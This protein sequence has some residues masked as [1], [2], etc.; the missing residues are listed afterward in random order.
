MK[1][2]RS[3]RYAVL[4]AGVFLG[5]SPA[6]AEEPVE[7]KISSLEKQ[8]AELKELIKNRTATSAN[9]S[10]KNLTP[11]TA[12][13]E[14]PQP[15]SSITGACQNNSETKREVYGFVRLDTSYDNGR[16]TP[17]NIALF[18][19]SESTLNNDGE[20]NLTANATRLGVNLCGPN[21]ETMMIGGNI[22]FDYLSFL[23]AENNSS[24]RLRHAYMKAFWPSSDFMIT[25][26]QT[27]DLNGTLIPFVDDPA[28][29]WDAGNIGG[30]H[31]QL[32]LTKGFRSGD[33]SRV[34]LAFA[35]ARSIGETNKIVDTINGYDPGKDAGIP[36]IQ[37]RLALTTPLFVSGKQATFALSG[38]Y[39]KE[40]WDTAADGTNQKV[41]SWSCVLE[42]S[43]PVTEKLHFSGELFSGENLDDY[44]GGIGQG[45]NRDDTNNIKAIRS[46][47]GWAALRYKANPETTLSIGAGMDDPNDS[48]LPAQTPAVTVRSLNEM[49][50]V[51]VSHT[52]AP[53]FI[54]GGQ[55]TH[56]RT[57][58]V[59]QQ[60]GDAL[61]VQS[62][63]TFTF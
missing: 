48:D 35:A 24:P 40:E 39:G 56:L 1:T 36:T 4:L 57:G 44:W 18:A 7:Q 46:H 26:G 12:T 3:L 8:I 23:G 11:A 59:N 20:L 17:G 49:Q 45:V 63:L 21:T 30:R 22:E 15:A 50:F 43:V 32:R 19:P 58:Y 5:S 34:E 38:H 52:I 51:S 31:P 16:I 27:W 14:P 13:K 55:I 60:E 29:M 42:L 41:D 9:T 47:G 6:L 28:I 62:S 37:G 2:K 10:A 53:H 54:L 33:E 61:R 25:A